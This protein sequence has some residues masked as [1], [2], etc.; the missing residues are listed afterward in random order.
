[1]IRRFLVAAAAVVFA[2]CITAPASAET[3]VYF[4]AV[5]GYSPH[6]HTW[7]EYGVDRYELRDI[8]GA[9]AGVIAGVD[10]H[11]GPVVIGGVADL[12][13]SNIGYEWSESWC[14]GTYSEIAQ[15]PLL[16][17]VRARI[18][19]QMGPVMPYA[20]AGLAVGKLH[21]EY[22]ESG[23]YSWNHSMTDYGVGLVYGGGLQFNIG[24]SVSLF[25]EA[26]HVNL[27]FNES[28]CGSCPI[29]RN[30]L[31]TTLIRGGVLFNF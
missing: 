17:T 10:V 2:L 31:S 15:L 3:T 12:S 27:N 28:S 9:T 11:L 20:T 4:G 1:M 26:L 22:S 23:K 19:F 13:W 30:G 16:G 8:S 14:C 25:G 7:Y 18:G 5:G 24:P 29:G 21:T 6:G